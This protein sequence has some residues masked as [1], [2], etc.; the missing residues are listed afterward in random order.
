MRVFLII[1]SFLG[2]GFTGR[3]QG[4]LAEV[5][6]ET[7]FVK[8]L[9]SGF[10]SWSSL[11]AAWKVPAD[12]LEK[13]NPGLLP[14]VYAG[15]RDIRVPVAGILKDENCTDCKPVYHRVKASEGLY[16]IG[17]W[18]GK[19][20]PA[21]LKQMNSLR[22][23]ALKPGQQLLVGYVSLKPPEIEATN[24]E[25]ASL[26]NIEVI[27]DASAKDAGNDTTL[28]ETTSTHAMDTII[29]NVPDPEPELVLSYEGYGLFADEFNLKGN[30]TK[31][32]GKAA[33][34]KSE[35]G[36]ADGRFYMLISHLKP[37]SIVKISNPLNGAYLFAKVVGPLPNIK[38]NNGLQYRVSNA[39]AA[40]L[41]FWK[42]DDVFDISLEY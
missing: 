25:G 29:V 17:I 24:P 28:T 35:S 32:L 8:V 23:D 39:A 33:S 18:Y 27:V 42:E 19:I 30:L 34:F 37:G 1:I 15:F 31:K 40:K 26:M 4:M 5:N 22:S 3:A 38:Q 2:F 16:R 41:G 14:G 6:N 9:I 20:A 7:A 36:W 11:S 13:A 21:K 12:A 10:E